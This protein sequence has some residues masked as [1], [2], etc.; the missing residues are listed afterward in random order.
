MN[1]LDGVRKGNETGSHASRV[2]GHP[3][4]INAHGVRNAYKAVLVEKLN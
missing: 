4:R 1:L 2:T 3:S